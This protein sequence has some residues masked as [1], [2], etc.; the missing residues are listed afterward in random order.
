MPPPP[1]PHQSIARSRHDYTYFLVI[2]IKPIVPESKSLVGATSSTL[3][4][5]R[6]QWLVPRLCTRFALRSRRRLPASPCT[7]SRHCCRHPCILSA[8]LSGCCPLLNTSAYIGPALGSQMQLELHRHW[9]AALVRRMYTATP[10]SG[11]EAQKR[12]SATTTATTVG[13]VPALVV[14]ELAWFAPSVVVVGVQ[15]VCV[16]VVYL[17]IKLYPGVVKL[18]STYLVSHPCLLI[19]A[20]V[21]SF[22]E[23]MAYSGRLRHGAVRSPRLASPAC[24]A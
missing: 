20:F 3:R 14:P 5:H 9:Y 13:L 21:S 15:H 1:Y 18:T 10:S 16:C 4:C 11:I 23:K 6:C 12:G 22:T 2:W 17:I 19:P 8:L 7:C 24:R